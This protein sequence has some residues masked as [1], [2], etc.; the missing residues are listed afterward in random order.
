MVHEIEINPFYGVLK[1]IYRSLDMLL[2]YFAFGH[3]NVGNV[4]SHSDVQHKRKRS[5]LILV[6]F[7]IVVVVSALKL[8]IPV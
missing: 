7:Y 1:G 8:R 6:G 3:K 5:L 2:F 4:C